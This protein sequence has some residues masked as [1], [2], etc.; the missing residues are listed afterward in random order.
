M[1]YNIFYNTGISTYIWLLGNRKAPERRGKLQLIDA[2]KLYDK[3]RKN[4][5][6][7]NCELSPKHIA[8]ILDT[9]WD[10]SVVEPITPEPGG[11]AVAGVLPLERNSEVPTSALVVYPSLRG[12]TSE[13]AGESSA[14]YWRSKSG[15]PVARS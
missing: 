9:Y 11:A 2:S 8:T 15:S 10:L 12:G 3:L 14:A 1:P 6:Q 7:K 4:L 13:S 5:G